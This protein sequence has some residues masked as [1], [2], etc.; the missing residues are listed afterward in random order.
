MSVSSQQHPAL[1]RAFSADF[2]SGAIPMALEAEGNPL[3]PSGFTLGV[4][5]KRVVFGGYMHQ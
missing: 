5:E 4:N 1:K 3:M 2:N